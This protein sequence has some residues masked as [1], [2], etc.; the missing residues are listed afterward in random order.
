[1]CLYRIYFICWYGVGMFEKA[2]EIV[3]INIHLCFGLG[4]DDNV[5]SRT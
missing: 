2:F 1:M 3:S 5:R 4:S